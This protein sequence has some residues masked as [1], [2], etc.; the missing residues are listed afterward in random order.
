LRFEGKTAIVTG[1]SR[2]IGRGIAE[3]LA[4]EGAEVMITARNAGPL[5][6]AAKEMSAGGRVIVPQTGNVAS[7]ADLDRLVEA[8]ME[9]WGRIDVLFNN[10]AFSEAEAF[11]ELRRDKWD[12]VIAAGLTAPFALS[13]R[14]ARHMVAAKS[15]VI[16]NIASIA[17]H[18][19]DGSVAYATAKTGLLAL[20]KDIAAELAAD[21]VRCVAVSPGW[22][23]TPMMEQFTPPELMQ[24][25]R[26]GGFD[27]VPL[28]RLITVDEVVAT[29]AF[30]AS[31]EASGMT[32]CE[33]LVDGGLVN[34]LYV[35][36]TIY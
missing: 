36:P 21:G 6:E 27:R 22:V 26:D 24:T 35:A 20:T 19:A 8:A 28:R 25:L 4:D 9:R 23:D 33:V 29:C 34:S 13:Q 15:G 16:V 5:D 11:L 30:V 7:E 32:G 2:G 14:V 12:R 3:R 17:A 31:D 10:A 18:G 1:G